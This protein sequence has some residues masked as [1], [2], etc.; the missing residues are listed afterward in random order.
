MVRRYRRELGQA[1]RNAAAI[2]AHLENLF[3]VLDDLCRATC[4]DCRD[5]CCRKAT[6]AFDH[7]DLIFLLLT[8]Q[9]VPG[10]HPRAQASAGAACTFLSP[11]GCRLPRLQRPWICTWYLCPTQKAHLEGGRSG[12]FLG[13]RDAVKDLRRRMESEYIAVVT[14]IAAK[15]T[16]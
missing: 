4:P 2:R 14:G 15:E 12:P 13:C 11:A 7:A 10:C 16:G 5:S 9:T 8:G 1:A 6:V 3:P